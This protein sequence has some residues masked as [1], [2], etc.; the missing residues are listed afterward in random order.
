MTS[1]LV[2]AIV[3]GDGLLSGGLGE[4]LCTSGILQALPKEQYLAN[5][6]A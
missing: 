4:S 2:E 6:L 3:E 1:L 5:R